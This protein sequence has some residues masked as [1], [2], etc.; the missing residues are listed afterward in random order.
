[1]GK[2]TDGLQEAIAVAKGDAKPARVT[3]FIP[4]DECPPPKTNYL[5]WEDASG[6]EYWEAI[7]PWGLPPRQKLRRLCSAAEF[8][9]SSK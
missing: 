4:F 9:N 8:H 6:R 5:T 3:T 2:I 1:M 7:T